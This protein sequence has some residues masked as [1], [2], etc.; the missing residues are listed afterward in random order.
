MKAFF[1]FTFLVSQL[2]YGLTGVMSSRILGKQMVAV[3]VE[4][5]PLRAE[6]LTPQILLDHDTG[7]MTCALNVTFPR[8]LV[9]TSQ[10]RNLKVQEFQDL[11]Y[12]GPSFPVQDAS[13]CG[14]KALPR[15]ALAVLQSARSGHARFVLREQSQGF[16]TTKLVLTLSWPSAQLV[17]DFE[18]VGSHFYILRQPKLARPSLLKAYFSV[19]EERTYSNGSGPSWAY[20]EHGQVELR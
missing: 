19:V 15:Q 18:P 20:L 6:A 1:L 7:D 4:Q 9:Q 14:I 10:F 5:M 13:E 17:G 16:E 3:D 12:S 2:S 8:A 11:V